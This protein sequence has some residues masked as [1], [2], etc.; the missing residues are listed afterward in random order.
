MTFHINKYRKVKMNNSI[1]V[2]EDKDFVCALT[3]SELE[4]RL[5]GFG[6]FRR[7]KLS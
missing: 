7:L 3:L 6:F 5:T 4:A 1:I 2:P